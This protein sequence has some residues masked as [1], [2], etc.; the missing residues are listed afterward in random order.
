[1]TLADD[2]KNALGRASI[3]ELALRICL[4]AEKQYRF[5]YLVEPKEL[6]Y[7]N[8]G[9]Y[10]PGGEAFVTKEL[11]KVLPHIS[12]HLLNETIAKLSQR[13]YRSLEDCDP[14][15]NVITVE[16]GLLDLEK[17]R[18]LPHTPDYLSIIKYPVRFEAKPKSKKIRKLLAETLDKN[19]LRKLL[20]ALGDIFVKGYPPKQFSFL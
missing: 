16:N 13:N 20:M 14:D 2:F 17:M 11:Q 12:Q 19:E 3:G 4:Q 6:R 10:Q 8:D 18:L 9:W 1:M 5:A 7:Y 15:K